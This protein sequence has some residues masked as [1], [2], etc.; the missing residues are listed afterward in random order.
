MDDEMKPCPGCGERRA[1]DE[2]PVRG[3]RCLTCRRAGVRAHYR[4]NRDYYLA[5]ARRRQQRVVL[6]TRAW[7][8][9][10]LR[11]H[12]CVDCAISNIRVLEFDHRD[13]ASKAAEVS[14]LA[15]SGYSLARVVEEV[16]KC[17]VRCANCHRMRTHLQR[18]W[19]GADI[20]ET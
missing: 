17:D 20:P 2:F 3:R 18:G 13:P 7:M 15:R 1:A 10:Y 9:D 4:A 19:W 16:A 8:I 12:P 14:F 6:E 11:Q 5:K